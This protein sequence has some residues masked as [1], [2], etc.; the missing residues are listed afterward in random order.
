MRFVTSAAVADGVRA[1]L[2]G[3]AGTSRETISRIELGELRSVPL[4]TIERVADALGASV[5][6]TVRWQ[7]EQ[8]DRLLDAAHAAIGQQIAGELTSFGWQVKTEVSFNH[9]GDRGRV[10]LLALH[11]PTRAVLLVEVKSALGDLQDTLGRLDIKVRLGRVIADS[12]GWPDVR[13]V[14][15]ALVIGDSRAARRAVAGH[16]ALFA[17]FSAR[18]RSARAW[19]RH[20][21]TPCPSGL[22]WFVGV[23]DSHGAGVMRRRRVRVVQS[24]R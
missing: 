17:R 4:S 13:L 6:L 24:S 3:R 20:P 7:G 16:D 8:L 12:V 2:G 23:P 9:F 19:V 18:G 10:D 5:D 15:P 1:D 14:V 22:L 21:T 11:A